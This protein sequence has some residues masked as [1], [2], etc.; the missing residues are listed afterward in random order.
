[1]PHDHDAAALCK[2]L[3]GS[4]L[5]YMDRQTAAVAANEDLKQ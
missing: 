2:H 4:V 3:V 5:F 1:M